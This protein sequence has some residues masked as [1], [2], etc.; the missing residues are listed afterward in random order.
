METPRSR[1]SLHL[2]TPLNYYLPLSNKKV[3]LTGEL[4][5]RIVF[6]YSRIY[7][8]TTRQIRYLQFTLVCLCRITFG[9]LVVFLV[10]WEYFL[11]V[12]MRVIGLLRELTILFSRWQSQESSSQ[13]VVQERSVTR[14]LHL[15]E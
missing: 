13:K 2:K 12:T 15:S 10:L 11:R 7:C 4:S 1:N 9:R 6:N 5:F 3:V 14:Y 8:G